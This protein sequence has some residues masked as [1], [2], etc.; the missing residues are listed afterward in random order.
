M[1]TE[2]KI[3]ELTFNFS[4]QIINLYKLLI[5]QN[6][7]VISKQLLRSATSIGA[8]VEEAIAAQSRKDFISKMSIA[9]KEARETRYWLRLLDT[10]KLVNADYNQYLQSIEHIINILTK[11]IK[12]TQASVMN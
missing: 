11:I 10:S 8:N 9:C 12:T 5:Q 3:L 4:L 2:N 7:Y 6:E 1:K